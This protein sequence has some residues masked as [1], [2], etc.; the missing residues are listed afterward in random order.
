MQGMPWDDLRYVLA[1][2]RF[3]SAAQAARRLE[4]DE[5]TVARRIAR[6]ERLLKVQLFERVRGKLLPT[7]AGRLAAERAMQIEREI[8]AVA[9]GASGAD[10]A[11]IGRVRITAVPIIVN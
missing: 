11:A 1:L 4:V 7:D 5:A 8:D 6:A 2:F 10:R 9:A 3:E